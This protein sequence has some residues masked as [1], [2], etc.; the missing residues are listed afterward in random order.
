MQKI[1]NELV[2][3]PHDLV[4]FLEGDFASW[5][6]RLYF[7][8]KS[9]HCAAVE[10]KSPFL[11][12]DFLKP[13]EEDE[14]MQ[15]VQRKGHEH[16][17][18]ALATLK[19]EFADLIEIGQDQYGFQKT[20]EAIQ[21]G[22]SMVYQGCLRDGRFLGYPDFLRRA[23][24]SSNLG[25]FH[26]EPW[27]TKL[28]KSAKPYFV[29]QLCAYADMLESIQKYRPRGFTF[30]FGDDTRVQFRTDHFFYYYR[31]LKKEFLDFQNRFDFT[32]MPEPGLERSYGRWETLATELLERSDHLSRVARI[33]RTQIKRLEAAGIATMSALA[34]TDRKFV[35]RVQAEVLDRLKAQAALQIESRTYDKPLFTVNQPNPED[36]RRGLALLPPPSR[37]DMFFDME[38]F[39]LVEGGLE[40]LFG[41]VCLQEGEAEFSD[42]W[43]HDQIQERRA[44]EQFIDWAY[45]RWRKDPAMHIYHY[46]A[47]ETSAMRRLM[48]KYATREQEV[49]NLLRNEVFVDLYTVVRQG[50][51]IGTPG[52]SLKDIECL[53]MG[54]RT[55]EVVSA[56]GSVVAYQR[57]LD[58]GQDEDWHHSRI[59]EEIRDYNRV[60]CE[61]LRH[62]RDWLIG[63]QEQHRIAY[64]PRPQ[65][66]D[67]SPADETPVRPATT[68][69]RRLL[70]EVAYS[71]IA[72]PER[73]RIQ[74]LLAW[75]LEF[76]WREAKPVWWR[77]FD[78]HEMTEQE[79][80]D[81]LDCLAGLHRTATPPKQVKRS[82]LY[83]YSFDPDQDTKLHEESKCIFAHDLGIKT[84]ITQLDA[85][86]GKLLIKLGPGAPIP[87]EQLNLIPDEYVSAQVIA[88]AVFRYVEAWADGEPASQA[89]DD[90]L[91]R[92]PPRIQGHTAE[93]VIRPGQDLLEQLI[94]IVPRMERTTLC[95]QGP[96]GT[97]KTFASGRII[98]QLLKAGKRIGVTANSHKAIL[99]IMHSVVEAMSTTKVGAKLFKAGE[100]CDD[101]LIQNGTIIKIESKAVVGVLAD[102]PVVVG[103]TAW[104]FS[105]PELNQKFDYLFIDEAGQFSLAN[106]VAVGSAAMNLVLVGDQMQLAQPIQGSHPGDSGRSGLEYLLDGHDTIP[107]KMGV[108]LNTT[109]R[110][111][112][113]ICNFISKAVYEG[114]LQADQSTATRSIACPNDPGRISRSSGIIFVPVLHEGNA[115]CSD[116]EVEVIWQITH[117]LI[118]RKWRDAD[119]TTRRLAMSDILFVAPY[120][121]QVRRLQKRLGSAARVGSVDKFQGLEAPVVIVSM[122]ASEIEDC[123]RGA[124]F[125]LNRNRI[126]V[127][128]SR[129]QCL[130]IVVGSPRIMTSRCQTIEQMELVNLYCWLT[131]YSESLAR[132]GR[133]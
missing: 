22:R 61:S 54:S 65:K 125:L 32:R 57:W 87:P 105:R 96:P 106:V 88:D 43:A 122:C 67:D 12:P 64:V 111:H 80:F 10:G 97:G 73:R 76:H 128:I 117:D 66:K 5:M 24:G 49:D 18:K 2:F 60:D 119:G 126:N 68:L 89:V 9:G 4:A 19:A 51:L 129:A 63:I 28:A 74:E 109:R 27:D 8:M 55:G 59:L 82:W 103:G 107:P 98:A 100:D 72:D 85:E 104:V 13:D 1:E 124:E 130:A 25:G 83:E 53:Y 114:R 39:P 50:V 46:A 23:E 133:G 56:S 44:F 11:R 62:L 84:T 48:G 34:T 52:Y 120:N 118:G 33:T 101:P 93:S 69:S 42:W 29:I 58:S 113:D 75:L 6:D 77:M 81:D 110:L 132:E 123:P 7:E 79:L 112:P 3:S 36:P 127:A 131:D 91:H 38:G 37:L 41:A 71:K 14:E 20:M 35:P 121:M 99:N 92:R 40:Y 86:N 95:I 45:A 115:Q 17:A 16:E 90:L 15:L 102:G 30:I 70:T 94:D 26:Y 108:F 31:R 21:A 116:E 78:R 47:Y